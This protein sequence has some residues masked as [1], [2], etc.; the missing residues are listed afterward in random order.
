MESLY[1]GLG[2]YPEFSKGFDHKVQVNVIPKS[3]ISHCGHPLE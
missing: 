3:R 2:E 1:I